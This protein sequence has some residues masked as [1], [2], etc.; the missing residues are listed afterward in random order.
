MKILRHLTCL[1]ITLLLFSCSPPKQ[2]PLRIGANTW[3]GYEPLF[4]AR[5][6]DIFDHDTLRVLRLTSA[7][8]V[9]QA[10][11]NGTLEGAALTLD[12][13]LS[14]IADGINVKVILVFDYSNGGDVLLAKPGIKTLE[15]LK[16]KQ[17]AVENTAVGA[18][19]LHSALDEAGLKPEEVEI[20]HHPVDEHAAVFSQYDAVVTF[21][22][23][24]T[25]ILKQG[26]RQL[27]HSG[28]I[29]GRI[30]DVLVMR[31]EVIETRPE[32]LHQLVNGYFAG[33][34]QLTS[35]PEEAISLITDIPPGVAT[36]I[37]EAYEDL[38]MKDLSENWNLLEGNPST[39]TLKA[40]SLQSF[41]M[42]KGLVKKAAELEEFTDARFLPE[43]AK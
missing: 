33:L 10:I 34:K 29:P 36:E 39:L 17:I 27:F 25:L 15:D 6:L 40:S 14:L 38:D 20:I 42:E 2:T 26:A 28:Q 5:D 1:I 24:R 23:A 7:T 43:A 16:G 12:E 35:N 4:L 32:A 8:E 37:R 18:I 9:I 31:S 13:T 41:M 11:R 22:P 19:L 3:P 30:I 21:E